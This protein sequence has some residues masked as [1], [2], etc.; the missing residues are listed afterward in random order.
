MK[1]E[2]ADYDLWESL[3]LSEQ[4]PA[5]ALTALLHDNPQFRLWLAAR[6]ERR[7]GFAARAESLAAPLGNR[8]KGKV[9]RRG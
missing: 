4:V 3:I 7:Q 2:P 5:A 9:K 6:A 8:R 1:V